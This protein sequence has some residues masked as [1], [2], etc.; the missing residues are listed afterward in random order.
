MSANDSLL[1][2]VVTN[3]PIVM[4]SLASENKVL[5]EPMDCNSTPTNSPAH[6]KAAVSTQDVPMAENNSVSHF[7]FKINIS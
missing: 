1:Q 2:P 3:G 4:N 5:S 6:V 7:I